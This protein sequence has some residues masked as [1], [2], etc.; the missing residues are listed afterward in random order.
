MDE[1]RFGLKGWLRRRWCPLGI[2]PPWTVEDRYEWLWLYTVVEPTTGWM[3]SLLLPEIDSTCLSIF[4]AEMCQALRNERI[5]VVLDGAGA[6]TSGQ[7]D[8]PQNLV[9]LPLPAY[10][11]ELNP[12]EQVFRLLRAKLSNRVFDSLDQMENELSNAVAI[13]QQDRISI[14][15]LTNYPWWQNGVQHITSTSM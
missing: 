1:A 15:R 4:W 9:G 12:A 3:L 7:V 2:R 14:Q 5:G 10:S 8:W 11:P 6:H 13:F